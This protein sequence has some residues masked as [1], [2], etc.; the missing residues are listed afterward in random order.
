MRSLTVVMGS[1]VLV[2]ALAGLQAGRLAAA[3]PAGG[4]SQEAPCPLCSA[5]PGKVFFVNDPVGRNSI[6]F[7][8]RAPLEDIVGTTNQIAGFVVFDPD[9]ADAGAT[10][11]FKVPVASLDTGIPMR[12][13]HLRS[14][15][16][17]DAA[18]HPEIVVSL[19]GL[20]DLESVEAKA[21]ARTWTAT[22]TG[23]IQLK[24][25]T[26]ALEV[27]VRFTWLKETDK[28]RQ[29]LP[30]NLL[31]GRGTFEV[32]LADFGITGPPNMDVIG[33]KVGSN[34]A[35]EVS[36]VATSQGEKERPCALCGAE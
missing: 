6:T 21:G 33:S 22:A 34:I 35:V 19:T 14:P 25:Q 11:Q 17:L 3:P 10:V 30:G 13:E 1:M 26:R 5:A 18:A 28:T 31:A 15:A 12:D 20:R 8:S 9:Q 27:A 2:T 24:G 29:R 7:T 32:A 4:E 36:F 23:E 16:W